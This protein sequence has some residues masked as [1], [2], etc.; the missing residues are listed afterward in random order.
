MG[1][2]ARHYKIP[3]VSW[4]L[5]APDT[6][7]DSLLVSVDPNLHSD[8]FKTLLSYWSDLETELLTESSIIILI[9]LLLNV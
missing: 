4:S 8:W 7:P 9:S 5:M 1:Q 3:D 6:Y 2:I